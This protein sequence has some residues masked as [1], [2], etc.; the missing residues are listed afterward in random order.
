MLGIALAIPNPCDNI[1]GV[2]GVAPAERVARNE[3]RAQ[4][5][6]APQK[7]THETEA[8]ILEWESFASWAVFTQSCNLS[9]QRLRR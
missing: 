2:A 7:N 3:V 5:E 1:G 8:H 4:G 9:R 6:T